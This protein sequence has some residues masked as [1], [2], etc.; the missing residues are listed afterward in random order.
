M[1]KRSLE[2]FNPMVKST[3]EDLDIQGYGS[4]L[5]AAVPLR[6]EKGMESMRKRIIEIEKRITQ[7]KQMQSTASGAWLEMVAVSIGQY[8][9]L[10]EEN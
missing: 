1:S 5:L 6:V 4:L 10:L 7:L 8:E 3:E 2:D 9:K